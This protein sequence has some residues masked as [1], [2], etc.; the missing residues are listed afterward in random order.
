[1]VSLFLTVVMPSKTEPGAPDGK[2]AAEAILGA[3]IDLLTSLDTLLK[4][5]SSNAFRAT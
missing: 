5:K 2:F 1:M 4:I 3:P